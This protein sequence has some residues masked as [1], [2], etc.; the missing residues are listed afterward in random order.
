[1]LWD[2]KIKV[3]TIH[4]HDVCRALGFLIQKSQPFSMYNLVDDGDTTYGD[5]VS[6]ISELFN[7]QV[8]FAGKVK[9]LM[10]K[11]FLDGI[12]SA[13]NNKYLKNWLEL[14][15]SFG[16][17]RTPIEVTVYKELLEGKSNC[18]DN[19]ALKKIGFQCIYSKITKELVHQ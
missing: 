15:Q 2:S 13:H 12:I 14:T 9:T 17:T 6:I 19:T 8:K 7:I 3:N 16:V 18:I 10:A 5:I 4:I 1:M 11:I